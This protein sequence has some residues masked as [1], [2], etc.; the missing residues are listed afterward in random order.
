[1]RRLCCPIMVIL[2]AVPVGVAA[3]LLS[4]RATSTPVAEADCNQV[5]TNM[6][7][8]EIEAI[9]GRPAD[10]R[11]CSVRR[12]SLG[13]NIARGFS[14]VDDS[15]PVASESLWYADHGSLW[16]QFDADGRAR[17]VIQSVPLDLSEFARQLIRSRLP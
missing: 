3:M 9:L 17:V 14:I 1:V 5:R 16:V 2:A 15:V 7:E 10:H 8:A 4:I 6:T 12:R 13:Q 11:G